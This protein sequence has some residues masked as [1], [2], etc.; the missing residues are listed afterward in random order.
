MIVASYLTKHLLTHG[1]VGRDW[2]A[3]CLTDRDAALA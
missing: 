3:E 2:L 1:R